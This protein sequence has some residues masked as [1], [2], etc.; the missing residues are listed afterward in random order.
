MV[1]LSDLDLLLTKYYKERLK[2]Q[3]KKKEIYT[4]DYILIELT[5]LTKLQLFTNWT[6]LKNFSFANLF[7]LI[8][9][10]LHLSLLP[11]VNFFSPLVACHKLFYGHFD[12]KQIVFSC[13]FVIIPSFVGIIEQFLK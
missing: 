1:T 9:P 11:L 12:S 6:S 4:T 5:E 7:S 10:S 3:R 2:P 13:Y 8:P